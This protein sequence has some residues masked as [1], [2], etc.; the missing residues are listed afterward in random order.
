MKRLNVVIN[1][2]NWLKLQQ[3]IREYQSNTTG[4]EEIANFLI[5]IMNST[6]D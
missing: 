3:A 1:D 5:M 4:C 2:E 6:N